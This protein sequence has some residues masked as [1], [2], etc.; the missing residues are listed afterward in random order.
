MDDRFALQA[1]NASAATARAP[2]V[3]D[4]R[5]EEESIN[6]GTLRAAALK[7]TEL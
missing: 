5:D 2:M 1:T 6:S 4:V 7:R 3:F